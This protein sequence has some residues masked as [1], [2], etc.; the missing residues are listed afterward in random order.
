MKT[1]EGKLEKG[2][3]NGRLKKAVGSTLDK[4]MAESALV[5]Q[6]RIRN[7]TPVDTGRLRQS[8]TAS[9][10]LL[11]GRLE[12]GQAEVGTNVEYAPY[13]EYGTKYMR[14]YAYMRLGAEN[15]RKPIEAILR[16]NLS[17]GGLDIRVD[18]D[19]GPYPGGAR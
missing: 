11:D 7:L 15:S 3:D 4:A 2:Y 9:A 12:E 18:A 1:D 14:P 10:R 6:G 17:P 8:I 16:R 5:M 19:I 13:V